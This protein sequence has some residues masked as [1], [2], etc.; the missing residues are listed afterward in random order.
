MILILTYHKVL[1]DPGAKPEFYTI[2][3]THLERQLELLARSGFPALTP[4]QLAQ[5][6]LPQWPA[7]LLTFDDATVDHYEVVAP[8][9]ARYHLRAVFF[10]PTAKLN[11]PGYLSAQQAATLSR[12]GHVLGLHSHEHRRLD[13]LG[14][15]DIRAQMERSRE[16]L[17]EL[18]GHPPVLFAPVGGFIN[19]RVQAIAQE[20]GVRLIRTMRWGYNGHPDP[21]AL[22][23][24]PINRFFTDEE[25]QRVLSFRNRSALYAAKQLTK[26]LVP[27]TAYEALRGLAFRLLG[28][29]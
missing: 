24:V 2:T 23:C 3:A 5:G 10:A 22:E 18:T 27:G 26:T 20:T 21:N 1:R 11:R 29:E 28:R 6:A 15:E 17:T 16:I 8:L 7:Y 13:R 4:E 9:L 25:F 14:E 19:R 12:A